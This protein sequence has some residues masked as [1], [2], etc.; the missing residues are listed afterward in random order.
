MI[1]YFSSCKSIQD[2]I[3]SYET[4]KLS[5]SHL[6]HSVDGV[7]VHKI[8]IDIDFIKT[9]L[10]DYHRMENKQAIWVNIEHSLKSFHNLE[11]WTHCWGNFPH[12]FWAQEGW[13]NISYISM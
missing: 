12:S 11:Y 1:F 4:F 3:A 2:N 8:Y 13:I 10:T 5:F 9:I 6:K 7:K